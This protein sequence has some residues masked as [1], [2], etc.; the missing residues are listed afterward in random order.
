MMNK[1]FVFGLIV[2]FSSALLP[3][4]STTQPL[5]VIERNQNSNKVYYEARITEN[6]S[7]ETKNPV[8]VYWILWAKDSSGNTRSEL[9]F[10][11]R[12]KAYGAKI[13]RKP[14]DSGFQITVAAFP[15][16]QIS[17]VLAQGKAVAATDIGGHP[18]RLERVFIHNCTDC[19]VPKVYFAEIFG[20]DLETG[21]RRYEKLFPG[22]K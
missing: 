1:V 16:H 13:K 22:G 19:L 4:R 21:E 15:A 6:G 2:A 9:N 12:E 5:F 20:T 18:S 14:G 7:F 3:A 11:E 8:H 10:I 17:V